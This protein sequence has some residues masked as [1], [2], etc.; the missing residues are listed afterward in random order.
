MSPHLKKYL[1]GDFSFKRLIRSFLIISVLLY[2]LIMV[3]AFSFADKLI[4]QPQ[5]SF[6]IDDDSII[7]I[8]TENGEK[9]SA[10]YFANPNA[11]FTI[12][13]SHGN[14][15]D[16]GISTPFFEELRDA[17]FSVFAYDYRGYGT[18]DGTPSE[19]NS[20]KDIESAYKY[21]TQELKLSS[22][23][24]IIHGRSLGGAV[25]VDLA[26]RTKCGGLIVESS[27]VS[28]FRVMTSYKLLPFDKFENINKIKNVK[29]P[30]LIIHGKRDSLIPFWHGEAL[31]EAANEPKFSHWVDEA[32][33]NNLFQV[34][35]NKY[36]R[37]IRDF[38][39]KI[40]SK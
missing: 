28:A 27:F 31:F 8:E 32:N 37:A 25:S 26:L 29:C 23:K 36:L 7:K 19:E 2:V 40:D 1:I 10:K 34:S 22:E 16:I 24:I 4:F 6:Y 14:A 30:V 21:L 35:R 20:Y 13:F 18:S 33:H 39:A 15:E 3:F 12:L 11:D 9:I 38:S 5:K 17:G